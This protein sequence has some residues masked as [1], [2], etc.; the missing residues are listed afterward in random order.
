MTEDVNT[1]IVI[2][3]DNYVDIHFSFHFGIKV[4]FPSVPCRKSNYVHYVIQCC[5]TAKEEK[6]QGGESFIKYLFLIFYIFTLKYKTL[7]SLKMLR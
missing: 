6:G 7:T 2:I 3:L 1:Y 5:E 4:F